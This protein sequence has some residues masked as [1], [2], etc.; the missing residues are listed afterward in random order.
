MASE[1]LRIGDVEIRN[2]RDLPWLRGAPS[3]MWPEVTAEQ[4]EPHKQWLNEKGNI[5]LH[6]GSFLIRSGGKTILVDTGIGQREREGFAV[7]RANLIENLAEEGVRP[8]DVDIVLISHVH[9]DHVGWNTVDQAGE[10]VLTFPNAEYWIRRKEFEFFTTDPEWQDRDY[11]QDCVLPLKGHAQLRLTDGEQNV[12][13]DITYYPAPGHTPDH[14]G[15][16]IRSRGDV[17]YLMGD[18]THHPVQVTE[19]DWE[20][21]IDIDKKQAVITRRAFVERAAQENVI[22]AAAHYPYPGWG[23]VFEEG[24]RRYWKALGDLSP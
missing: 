23:R 16:I 18:G 17:A 4:W 14:S 9:V 7:K 6:L 21:G 8:G 1:I 2:I 19:T 22:L 13:E 11:I 12:T 20:F 15:L 10:K 24:G 5:E 3:Y